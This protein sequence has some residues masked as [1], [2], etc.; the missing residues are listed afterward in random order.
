MVKIMIIVAIC[1]GLIFFVVT[2]MK[3]NQGGAGTSTIQENSHSQND[4][5]KNAVNGV[6]TEGHKVV[7]AID[8][9]V[10]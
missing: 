9:A 8:N 7:N 5:V 3:K 4:A 1:A 6:V 10:K 2:A